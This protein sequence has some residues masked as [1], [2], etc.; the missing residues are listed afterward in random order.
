MT[1]ILEAGMLKYVGKGNWLPGIPARDLSDEDVKKYA[2][3]EHLAEIGLLKTAK[4][5]KKKGAD[6][7]VSTGL[8]EI[9]VEKVRATVKGGK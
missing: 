6:F 4:E 2:S 9:P 3:E 1:K 8:Y 5:R 7:L